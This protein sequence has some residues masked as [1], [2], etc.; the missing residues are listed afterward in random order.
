MKL[1]G[2]KFILLI[3]FTP[4]KE[5]ET[6]IQIT[7]RTRFMKLV[8]LFDKEVRKDFEKEKSF[9]EIVMPKFEPWHYGPFSKD[10]LHDLEFLINQQYIEVEISSNA[11]IPAEL[12]E[13]SFWVEN[14]DEF[15][16]RE[17]DEE[18]FKLTENKGVPKAK[19]IW[20]LLTNDQKKILVEFKDALN[21]ASLD[22]ILDYVYKKYQKYGYIDKSVIR[23]KY[24]HY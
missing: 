13:Y 6:N 8:F 16:S 22:R 5:G 14:L 11:P 20:L 1:T 2:K 9:E 23:K 3:L 24:L 21:S 10:L 15:Q 12:E 7:G 18:I 19:D 4:D 17:Y